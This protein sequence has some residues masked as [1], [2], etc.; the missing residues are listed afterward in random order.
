[1][2]PEEKVNALALE[3]EALKS[4]FAYLN[5]RINLIESR[6]Q[7]ASVPVFDYDT[8]P[9]DANSTQAD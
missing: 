4:Q 3:V 6:V 9:K 2:T 5:A 7:Q 1:M 8:L